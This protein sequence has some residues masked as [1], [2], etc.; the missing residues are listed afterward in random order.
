MKRTILT[1]LVFCVISFTNFAQTIRRCNNNPGIT[2]LNVYSTLQA[3]HDA[4]V[5]GDIIYLEPSTASYGNLS[6]TKQLTYVGAGYYLDKAVNGP[7]DGRPTMA[8]QIQLQNG[9]AGSILQGLDL[10]TTLNINDINITVTRCQTR[11]INFSQSSNQ[12]A[13]QNSRGNN[14]NIN[15][16]FIIGAVSGNNS[17]TVTSQYG[18]NCIIS[19]NIFYGYASNLTNSVISNNTMAYYIYTTNT[20]SNLYGCSISNNII[21]AR[22]VASPINFVN[23]GLG[24]SISNNICL[25]QTA[26]PAGN[27]NVQNGNALTTY[28]VANPWTTY[29]TEDSKFALIAG[30]PAIGI[31]TGGTDAGA[32]LTTGGNPIYRLSGLPPYPIIT[33]FSVSGI[34]NVNTPLNVNVS[35]RSNN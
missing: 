12:I 29:T 35:A 21:D 20:L 17:V 19:N 27:G 4:A 28:I 30:S 9:T 26:S 8:G 13:G 15:S 25:G 16:C 34:G 10:Q 22:G 5:A 1:T 23:G 3:A 32:I 31:G 18:Y 2:G 6:A 24:N 7:A 33:N 11:N 14:A